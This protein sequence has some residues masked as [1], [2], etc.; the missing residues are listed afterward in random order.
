M[1]AEILTYLLI[2]CLLSSI[3]RIFNGMKNGCFYSKGNKYPVPLLEKYVKNLHFIE[4]P[5]WYCQ[6]GSLFF[7][8]LAIFRCLNYTTNVF[9]ILLQVGAALLVVM[10]S[11]GMASFHFQ[12]FINHGSNLPWVDPNENPKS[13]FAW[14]KISFWWYRPWYGKRR[15]MFIPIGL[16][17]IALGIYLGIFL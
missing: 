7:S 6:F 16:I 5:L 1:I 8:T 2:S 14:G 3:V 4:T 13:E 12:G 15:V 11:S 17:S 10:G 9:E